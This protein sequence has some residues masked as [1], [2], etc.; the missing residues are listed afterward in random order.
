LRACGSALVRAL[1]LSG[2]LVV[3]LP[4]VAS[5]QGAPR[6]PAF[7]PDVTFGIV[8]DDNVF[9]R[10]EGETTS[11]IFMRLTPGFDVVKETPRLTLNGSFR[12]DAERYQEQPE[13][14]EA[15]ARQAT[16]F[17]MTWRPNRRFT[18]MPSVGYQRTQTPQDINVTTG[19]TGGRQEAS[20]FN[21]SLAFENTIRPQRR[22]LVGGEYRYD[23]VRLGV[24]NSLR[25]VR[26]RYTE[27]LDPRSQLY[28]NYRL[29]QREFIPGAVIVSHVGVG[30]WSYRLT[31]RLVLVLEGGPRLAEGEWS[32]EVNISATQTLGTITTFS[33]GYAHTQDAAVGVLGLIT[34]DRVTTSI[35]MRRSDRW[36]LI[37]SAGAFR[38]IQPD[39]D[40]VAYDLSVSV[41]RRL[42]EAFWLV[43]SAVRTFNDL[44][45]RGPVVVPP[46]E[47]VRN[48]LMISVRV[49]PFR[50]R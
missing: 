21:L 40:T 1:V 22:V 5:A 7:R 47:I 30:G 15:V 34:V 13:L 25:A 29:E 48:A 2:L 46:A 11:D 23:D 42:A 50:P 37:L 31:P 49:Q 41:G 32:P 39:A 44:E 26:V 28:F 9:M 33:A 20:S 36:E 10:P 24:D 12:F 45:P 8:F 43:A 18:F 38:N 27:E 16:Q 35:A 6:I 4:A 14:N 17:D 19:L 3:V